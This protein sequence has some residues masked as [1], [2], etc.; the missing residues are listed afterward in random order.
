MYSLVDAAD[1]S[2]HRKLVEWFGQK[3]E[4]KVVAGVGKLTVL[5]I[6]ILLSCAERRMIERVLPLRCQVARC[7]V[8]NHLPC[9]KLP[10]M[11][12]EF[13]ALHDPDAVRCW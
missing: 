11:M 3:D 13:V 2:V 1:C 4:M 10:V 8:E 7:I 6:R 5:M 9:D 12:Q